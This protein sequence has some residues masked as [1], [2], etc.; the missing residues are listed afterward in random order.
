[1]IIMVLSKC[2]WTHHESARPRCDASSLH[3]VEKFGDTVQENNWKPGHKA[4][5]EVLDL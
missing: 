3:T 4:L 5:S 2:H 1:M